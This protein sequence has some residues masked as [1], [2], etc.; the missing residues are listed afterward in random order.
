MVIIV[1]NMLDM[2]NQLANGNSACGIAIYN[3]NLVI[4]YYNLL[5]LFIGQKVPIWYKPEVSDSQLFFPPCVFTMLNYSVHRRI[6]DV[7]YSPPFYTVSNGYKL[8]LAIYADGSGAGLGT[9]LSVTVYLMKGEN[10]KILKWPFRANI[11]IHVLNW[12]QDK[13]HI[14]AVIDHYNAPLQFRSRVTQGERAP[15]GRSLEDLIIH[16][17]L[18]NKFPDTQFL[19]VLDDAVSFRVSKVNLVT[20][21]NT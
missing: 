6:G 20:G 10:D 5:P 18:D 21:D 17:I 2:S 8:Q 4:I 19:D 9:H 11:T 1:A 13:K 12:K 16:Y 7:W 3:Y 15:G 14:E